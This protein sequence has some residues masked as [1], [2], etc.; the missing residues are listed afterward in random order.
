MAN[1]LRGE[2]EVQAG[3]RKVV[4]RLGV[5]EMIALQNDLGLAG[6]DEEFGRVIAE[7]SGFVN[8]R[9]V[10]FHGLRLRQPEI[11]LEEVGDVMTELG[12]TRWEA[13]ILEGLRWALPEKEQA[14]ADPKKGGKPRPSGGPTSS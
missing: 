6:K 11:T 10:I 2:V 4:F 13:V 3:G 7:S 8:P 9:L 5:N 1:N 14:P 12:R